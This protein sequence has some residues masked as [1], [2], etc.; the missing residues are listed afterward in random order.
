MTRWP[1]DAPVSDLP[2]HG[3]FRTC[4]A[5]IRYMGAC[6]QSRWPPGVEGGGARRCHG[7]RVGPSPFH[8]LAGFFSRWESA[9]SRPLLLGDLPD[10][11]PPKATLLTRGPA[12]AHTNAPNTPSRPT[13]AFAQS[14]PNFDHLLV[15]IIEASPG[16]LGDGS[17]GALAAA[18]AL[19]PRAV[20]VLIVDS[21]GSP[22]PDAA[23]ARMEAINS[24]LTG[25][26]IDAGGVTFVERALVDEPGGNAAAAVGDTADA[27]G[28]TLCIISSDA[29]HSRGA[30]A[31][32]LAE[33]VD[34]PLLLLP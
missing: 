31:N 11:Q 32:L 23:A 30:D 26:G 4:R 21:A 5:A 6:I 16:A 27:A 7:E 19:N 22:S 17:K 15:P 18:G 1:I 20:T 24:Y 8:L 13:H 34:C 33:F 10:T 2:G 9:L 14:P 12:G 25:A 29:V 3:G 28:A